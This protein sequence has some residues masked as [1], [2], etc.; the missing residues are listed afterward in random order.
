MGRGTPGGGARGR[1][2]K[3]GEW[4]REGGKLVE[5]NLKSK[6]GEV[7]MVQKE[8]ANQ[9]TFREKRLKGRKR[10]QRIGGS[11]RTAQGGKGGKILLKKK[12]LN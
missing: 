3:G 2:S 12:L 11:K 1:E 9:E 6:A 8:Q 5:K 4:R 7:K 10:E